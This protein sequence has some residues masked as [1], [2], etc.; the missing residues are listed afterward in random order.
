[1]AMIQSHLTPSPAFCK[2]QEFT[3]DSCWEQGRHSSPLWLPLFMEQG[4]ASSPDKLPTSCAHF[5]SWCKR[6]KNSALCSKSVSPSPQLLH[7][8]WGQTVLP[9]MLNL[10]NP[11]FSPLIYQFISKVDMQL[12]LIHGR[13][14]TAHEL[15]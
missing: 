2:D 1:M 4:C 15:V 9:K 14:F 11:H 10:V 5:R 13:W 12:P 3:L 7:F 6:Q 8:R